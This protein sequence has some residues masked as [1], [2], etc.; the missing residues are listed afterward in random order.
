LAGT[1]RV[2][3]EEGTV[4]GRADP[5]SLAEGRGYGVLRTHLAIRRLLSDA[6]TEIRDVAVARGI[7]LTA[8]RPSELDA[9]TGAVVR[10]GNEAGVP[11]P[12]N[13]LLHD[14]ATARAFAAGN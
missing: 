7:H 12:V 9:W 3:E 10:L 1:A 4:V 14:L 13:T 6:T 8:G 5:D 2:D 11:T